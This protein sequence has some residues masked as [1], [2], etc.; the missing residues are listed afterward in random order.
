MTRTRSAT[1]KVTGNPFGRPTE[2]SVTLTPLGKD[3]ILSI[4]QARRHGSIE[5]SLSEIAT[6]AV[7]RDAQAKARNKK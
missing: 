5:V 3:C 6:A 4:H 7:E 1:F 2:L